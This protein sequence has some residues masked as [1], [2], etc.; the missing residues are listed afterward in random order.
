MGVENR[1]VGVEG[2]V[3]EYDVRRL[4]VYEVGRCGGD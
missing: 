1:E 2:G 4:F 3:G